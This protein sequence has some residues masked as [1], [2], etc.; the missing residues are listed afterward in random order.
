MLWIYPDLES[1][2]RA[3]ADLFLRQADESVPAR[4]RFSVALSGGRTPRRT[5]ELL[6]QPPWRDRID[7]PRIFIFWGDERCVPPDVLRSSAR[8]AREALLGHV[9]LPDA[10]IH[11]ILCQTSPEEAAAGYETLLRAFFPEGPPVIDLIFLGL[12]ADGHTASLFPG[13]A[14]P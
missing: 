8:L 5:Y 2:S 6:A 13:T 12:G 4:G 3:A 1:L 10:Q 7:W 14:R 9:P 11:P